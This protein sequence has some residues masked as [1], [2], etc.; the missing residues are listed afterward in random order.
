M[1]YPYSY[2]KREKK[3]N[4]DHENA[5]KTL[6]LSLVTLGVSFLFLFVIYPILG[7]YLK[8]QY[9]GA[10]VRAVGSDFDND[11]GAL[12]ALA[13]TKKLNTARR[14][15]GAFDQSGLKER[16]DHFYLSIPSLKIEKAF[17]EATSTSIDP[18]DALVH[19]LGTAEP[20]SSG[21]VF[22]TGHST[23][24]YLF[25]PDNPKTIFSTLDDLKEG[26]KIIINYNDKDFIY[27][28]IRKETLKPDDVSMY[29]DYYPNFLN[30]QTVT[31]MTCWPGGTTQYRMLVTAE[32]M[33]D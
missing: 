16:V 28:V 20:G 4:K 2:K 19:I 5:R 33:E 25:N 32:L 6:G 12:T 1:I 21:N 3:L 22:I 7:N 27:K 11:P 13:V 31:L 23:F 18:S 15:L 26:G 10:I 30:K 24:K 8:S 29:K 14:V 9:T 17:V